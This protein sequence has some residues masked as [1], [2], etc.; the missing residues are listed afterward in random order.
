MA[1]DFGGGARKKSLPVVPIVAI[2]VLAVA[3]AVFAGWWLPRSREVAKAQAWTFTGPPCPTATAQAFAASVVQ[4]RESFEFADVTFAR[5]YGH[6]SCEQITNDGGKGFGTH[7]VC[8]FTA[9]AV[10]HVTTKRGD[11]YF[12]TQTGPATVAVRDGVASCV[13]A[14][15]F[16]G[17]QGT[18]TDL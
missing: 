2:L 16:R 8:Q 1:S 3:A 12:I 13:R 6:A 5:G 18:A 4:P 9:P 17:E 10:L 7:P 14:A 11:F 15:H